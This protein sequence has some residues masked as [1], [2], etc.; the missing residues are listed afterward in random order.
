[1]GSYT[2]KE[3]DY[4]YNPR[5]S[6]S[7]FP[8]IAA[9][10]AERSQSVRKQVRCSL[11]VPYGTHPQETLDIFPADKRGAPVHVFFHGGY[12]RS[13]DKSDYSFVAPALLQA[14]FNVVIPNYAL[15]PG[16][17]M[18]ELLQQC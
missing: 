13:G 16:V 9:D 2:Q 5:L 8:Q 7:D 4:Q 14:G 1:Y 6:V 18:D 17:T 11:D 15:C 3:L 12:W 10:W